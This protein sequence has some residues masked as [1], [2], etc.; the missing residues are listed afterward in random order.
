MSKPIRISTQ[1]RRNWLIDAVLFVG[2][3]IAALSGIYFLFMPSA[4]YRGGRNA[5]YGV[6]VLFERAA[7]SDLHT[8]GGVLMIAAAT[9]HFLVH[10]SWV[11]MMSKRVA[12]SLLTR[13]IKLSKGGKVNL[14]VDAVIAVSFLLAA[15][16]GVYFLFVSNGGFGGGRDPAW[17]PAFLFSRTTWDLIHTWSGVV[18]ICAAVVHFYIHWRW[19][20]NVTVKFFRSLLPQPMQSP[21]QEKMPAAR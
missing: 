13:D 5:L 21:K 19:V 2:A 1:T 8:W 14:V 11:K 4:G 9:V 7:W 17:D 6:Q 15:V 12:K 20:K 10:W 18:M 3:L 16:S